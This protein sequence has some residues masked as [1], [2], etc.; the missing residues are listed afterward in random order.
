MNFITGKLHWSFFRRVVFIISIVLLVSLIY[1]NS[2]EVPFVFDDEPNISENLYLRLTDLSFESLKYAAFESPCSSRPLPNTSFALNYY[3]HKYDL[4]GYHVVNILIHIV[5]GI[6]L[7]FLL[8]TT[9][10][11]SFGGNRESEIV[12]RISN[13]GNKKDTNLLNPYPLS[14]NPELIAICATLLWIVHPLHTQSVTYIVQR[15]TSMAA[16]FY[17]LSLLFY[18]K[19]RLALRESVE[20]QVIASEARQSQTPYN[21]PIT[22]LLQ[23]I[24]PWLLFTA[25]LL[26]G[27]CAL[28]SKQ[29][30]AT[31]PLFILLY[32]WYFFQDLRVDWIKK[33]VVFII[34]IIIFIG[35]MTVLYVGTNPINWILSGYGH[36]DFTLGQRVLTEFRVVI[37]YISLLIFPHPSRLT[38]DHDFSLSY[39]L[40]NPV[41]TVLSLL[42]LVALFVL[43]IYTAK[44]HRLISFAILWFLGNLAIE[45]SVIGL[46]LVYEHRT[47]LP[48]MFIGLLLVL[49]MFNYIPSILSS[50]RGRACCGSLMRLL[51]FPRNDKKDG[52]QRNANTEYQW[53]NLIPLLIIISLFSFWTYERNEVWSDKLTFLQD[54]VRKAPGK[55]RVYNNLGRFLAEGGETKKAFEALTEA[56]SIEPHLAEARYNLAKAFAELG[57]YE[58]AIENYKMVLDI[59]PQYIR[60][61]I[62][63]GNIYAGKGRYIESIHHYEEALRIAPGYNKA[64]NN[65]EKVLLRKEKIDVVISNVVSSLENDSSNHVLWYQLGNLYQKEGNW[66]KAIEG[67]DRVLSISPGYIPALYGLAVVNSLRGEYGKSASYLEKVLEL[68]PESADAYYNMACVHSKWGR[69]REAVE[70]LRGAVERGFDDWELLRT[71]IDLTNIRETEYYKDLLVGWKGST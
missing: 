33:R 19:G 26:S 8:K 51:R 46:E 57:N 23:P 32:E 50:L 13:T 44:K 29:I 55:A 10:E 37:L 62:N 66:D 16:M 40:L 60:A 70:Y 11:L 18:V 27:I 65:L 4:T 59:N 6:L 71:D 3:F 35:I 42:V 49:L 21:S 67:Y 43:A 20:K 14:L 41:T 7:Y 12:N 34:G 64:R 15:M 68:Q 2:L 25:S 17:I 24:M 5:T 52:S 31:L 54:A 30:A 1:R 36:R 47:Y 56:L 22:R 53:V 38:L 58:S 61:H 63:L 69:E 48:S 39:S 9:V 45:S 28:A